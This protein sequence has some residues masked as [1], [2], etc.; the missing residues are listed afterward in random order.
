MV[1]LWYKGMDNVEPVKFMVNL[2]TTF[3]LFRKTVFDSV[4]S[5]NISS[6]I[7]TL[8]LYIEYNIWSRD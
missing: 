4:T 6:S 1:P 3:F 2:L 8:T 7:P 5:S